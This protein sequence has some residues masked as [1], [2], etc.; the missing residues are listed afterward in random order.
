[1][2][3][4]FPT[5]ALHCEFAHAFIGGRGDNRRN[6]DEHG[7]DAGQPRPLPGKDQGNDADDPADQGRGFG[8]GEGEGG[9]GENT[10]PQQHAV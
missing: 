2:R 5:L 10:L 4:E 7:A 3:G 9:P 8:D 1:V 6:D